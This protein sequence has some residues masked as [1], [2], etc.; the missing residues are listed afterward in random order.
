MFFVLILGGLKGI[1]N[2]FYGNRFKL[3]RKSSKMN[4]SRYKD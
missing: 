4:I 2:I 1:F 3:N